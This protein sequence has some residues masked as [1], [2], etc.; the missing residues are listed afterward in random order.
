MVLYKLNKFELIIQYISIVTLFLMPFFFINLLIKF[1]FENK[2][3]YILAYFIFLGLFTNL[4][5]LYTSIKTLPMYRFT[6]LLQK[7][8]LIYKKLDTVIYNFDLSEIEYISQKK[9]SQVFELNLKNKEKVFLPFGLSE[10]PL[11]LNTLS[12]YY[13]PSVEYNNKIFKANKQGFMSFILILIFFPFLI[14]PLFISPY[15]LILYLIG[16]ILTLVTTPN[17]LKISN[18]KLE[19]NK[20]SKIF[21][22]DLTVIID[23]EEIKDIK[24]EHSYVPRSGHFYQCK[25][26]T[27]TKTYTLGGFGISDIDLYCLLSY[28]YKTYNK[29]EETNNLPS[30]KIIA[31]DDRYN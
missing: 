20:K 24:L 4:F 21:I 25:L 17:Y 2:I 22:S 7:S 19:I 23:L 10:I 15:I 28:W 26:S 13:H 16:F 29:Y 12:E 8:S 1:S 5:F 14:I 6:I 27:V 30:G 11:F 18:N 31:H 3:E 9:H